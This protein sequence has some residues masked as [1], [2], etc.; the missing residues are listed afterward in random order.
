MSLRMPFGRSRQNRPSASRVNPGSSRSILRAVT[1]STVEI[2]ESRRLLAAQPNIGINFGSDRTDANGPLAVAP[3]DVAGV[4][5]ITNWNNEDGA[6]GTSATPLVDSTGA[7]TGVNVAWQANGTWDAATQE[8]MTD[9]FDQ[10]T[11]H[12]DY[13]LMG[14]Y[15]DN[16]G[17]T[18]AAT[19]A[20]LTSGTLDGNGILFSGLD[21]T[22]SYDVYVYSLTAVFSRPDGTITVA[23]A[24]GDQMQ[25]ITTPP[26]TV[27][28][29]IGGSNGDYLIYSGVKPQGGHILIHGDGV[30]FRCAFNGIELVPSAAAAPAAPTNLT[31]KLD[32]TG[33]AAALSF[34]EN[35]DNALTYEIQRG[36]SQNG[37]FT[38]ITTV[39]AGA[40]GSTGTYTDATIQPGVSYFYQVRARNGFNGGTSSDPSNVAG[41]VLI[42]VAG[43]NTTIG[44]NFGA[45]RTANG[46]P[47]ALAPTDT[48]GV[49]PIANWNNENGG[50]GSSNVLKDLNGNATTA[51][52]K[53]QANGTWDALQEDAP[54]QF[55]GADHTLMAGYLDNNGGTA[56]ATS[57]AF[58]SGNLNG[59]GVLFTGLPGKAYDVYVYSLPSVVGRGGGITVTGF[60]PSGSQT[61]TAATSTTFVQGTNYVKFSGISPANGDLL[62]TPDGVS[63]RDAIQGIELIPVAT[64]TAA[65]GA[66]TGL[67]ATASGNAVTLNW[68]DNSN[69]E[70]GFVV[71]R[72]ASP[73]GPFAPIG[74]ASAASGTGGKVTFVDANGNDSIHPK[75]QIGQTYYYEVESVNS[76]N[77]GTASAPLGPA[78]V[79][80]GVAGPGTEAHYFPDGYWGG[81]PTINTIIPSANLDFGGTPDPSIQNFQNSAIFTGTITATVAGTYTFVNN[82]DDDGYLFVNGVLV[83]DD[84]GGH[85]Q[86]DAADQFGLNLTAGQKV[87]YVFFQNQGGG[88][89]GAHIEWITPNAVDQTTPVAVPASQYTSSMAQP[90]APTTLAV[91]GAAASHN[92]TFSFTG[93]DNAVVFYLLQRRSPASGATAAGAWQTVSRVDPEFRTIQDAQPVP[94]TTYDYRVVAFNFDTTNFDANAS[95]V[96]NVAVPAEPSTAPTGALAHYFNGE[97]ADA[98]LKQDPKNFINNLVGGSNPVESQIV[99]TVDFTYNNDSP[100]PTVATDATSTFQT[101]EFVHQD[102]FATVWT[103]KIHTDAAGSYTFISNSD[104]DGYLYVND[105]LVSSDPGGHGE[106]DAP[107]ANRHPLTLLAN[108]NYNFVFIQQERNGGAGAHI[109]WIE[110]GQTTPAIIGSSNLLPFED[111]PVKSSVDATGKVTSD[112]TASAAGNLTVAAA[113]GGSGAT[114]TWTDQSLS[115]LWFVVERSTDGGTTFTPIAKAGFDTGTFTDAGGTPGAV[116]RVRGANWDGIGPASN[117]ATLPGNQFNRADFNHSGKVDFSDLLILAQNYGKAA[118]NAHGDA[119]GDGKVDFSDLLILAQNYNKTGPE[120]A[121]TR[122]SMLS[123]VVGLVKTH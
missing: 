6:T 22:K 34:T 105:T 3:T 43:Q 41:P 1:N 107:A 122:G 95:N 69:N 83:S 5:P 114:L 99:N 91:T 68:T 106:Q 120:A 109:E 87:N 113:T 111:V 36:T 9:Q 59:N 48:A 30:S 82:T 60:A 75:L 40:A 8:N 25:M 76:F 15:L 19:D 63:F 28:S 81:N 57:A 37:P 55:T 66:P 54:D 72:S 71:L 108:T 20:S 49:V 39:T 121:K 100:D 24:N 31:A 110:P 65:P 53:W 23:G 67:T 50:T 90:K 93:N 2:L 123:D 18:A 115:E 88:G 85:G 104:D 79:M 80:F 92:V 78:N 96:V 7:T 101:A 98:D 33:T 102:D 64:E 42:Q 116:Y 16:Y 46:A 89:S 86:Q 4:V 51:G 38:T 21:N 73:N 112:T 94:G 45:D 103:G 17:G 58:T 61:I 44:V 97:I 70:S 27:N 62:V 118:D 84:P 26:T 52:L 47:L 35:A 29:Y 12:G 13:E 32:S 74:G 14:G 10:T 117:T 77:G 56:P 119:N 11:Q